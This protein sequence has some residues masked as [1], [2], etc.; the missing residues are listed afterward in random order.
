MLESK[1]ESQ[2]KDFPGQVSMPLPSPPPGAR[3]WAPHAPCKA[4]MEIE[5]GCLEKQTSTAKLLTLVPVLCLGYK[6]SLMRTTANQVQTVWEAGA[7]F[8]KTQFSF[9]RND[10]EPPDK[11]VDTRKYRAEPKSIYEYQPGKSSVLTS[12]KMVM[13]L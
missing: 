9:C 13:W 12:E 7:V 11:K 10:W 8:M 6:N 5:V 4:R 3:F 1:E 2:V